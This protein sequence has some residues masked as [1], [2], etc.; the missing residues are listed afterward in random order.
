ME[1]KGGTREDDTGEA[2]ARDIFGAAGRAGGGGQ[3]VDVVRMG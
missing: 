3:A 1:W 2:G